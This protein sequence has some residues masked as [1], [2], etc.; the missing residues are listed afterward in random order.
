MILRLDSEIISTYLLRRQNDRFQEVDLLEVSVQHRRIDA[1]VAVGEREAW[2]ICLVLIAIFYRCLRHA[3]M[4][5]DERVV[6]GKWSKW[7]L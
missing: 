4:N 3:Q 5:L 2:E 1:L 7:G 6:T